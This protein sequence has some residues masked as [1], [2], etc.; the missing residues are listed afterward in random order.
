MV[1][2]LVLAT[3]LLG[4][5]R[6]SKKEVFD[7]I[8]KGNWTMLNMGQPGLPQV[9]A[10][11]CAVQE[12]QFTD[13]IAM[14]EEAG[15]YRIPHSRIFSNKQ[16]CGPFGNDARELD[17]FTEKHMVLAPASLLQTLEEAK[18]YNLGA[19]QRLLFDKLDRHGVAKHTLGA[20]LQLRLD[21]WVGFE[22]AGARICGNTTVLPDKTFS[23]FT[24]VKNNVDIG[25][26]LNVESE[27]DNAVRYLGGSF[28]Y[29]SFDEPLS[30]KEYK[31]RICPATTVSTANVF[32]IG[33]DRSSN[34]SGS[35]FPGASTVELKNGSV[36][37]LSSISVGDVVRSG[38]NDFSTVFTFTHRIQEVTSEFVTL[39]TAFG[40]TISLTKGH[41]IYADGVLVAA[42]SVSVGSTV[43]LANG[44]SER[45]IDIRYE[46]ATGL[47]NPQTV[48]GDIVVNGIVASTYTTAVD[49]KLAHV[50]LSPLRF[51]SRFGLYFTGLDS[52][53]GSLTQWTAPGPPTLQ[54]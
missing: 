35:C 43:T 50:L 47:Y 52:G 41:Y 9:P 42:S 37:P 12:T 6:A 29:I 24:K 30:Q 8:F 46:T 5:V 14:N 54:S 33:Q 36:V 32:P 40:A 7:Q 44:A 39:E 19:M 3:C 31:D 10:R 13:K 49:P 16:R 38:P 53:G 11:H 1:L 48:N 51:V 21:V 22:A 23:L 25:D 28:V 20:F 18:K 34:E 27:G 15:V 26:L 4:S 2:S 17:L 45:V